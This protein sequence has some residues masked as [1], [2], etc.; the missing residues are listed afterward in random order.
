MLRNLKEIICILVVVVVLFF[1]S[2]LYV[3]FFNESVIERLFFDIS[4]SILAEEEWKNGE[5]DGG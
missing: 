3:F 2:H 5:Y 1:F 4:E